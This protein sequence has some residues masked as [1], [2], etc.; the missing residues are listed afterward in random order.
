M[1]HQSDR[2][3]SSMSPP[4]TRAWVTVV[5]VGVVAAA[6]I[7][8]L[9]VALPLL[10][11]ELGMSLVTAG[12]LVGVIQLASMVGG[13][14]VAW[15]GEMAGLRRLI[16]IGLLLLAVG[17]CLGATTSSANLMMVFR[18][19]EG[20]GFLLCT[21]LAPALIRRICR[22]EQLNL[23][24]SSWGAF[25]GTATVVGFAGG[26][27]LLEFVSWRVLWV[28]MAAFT[29][30][31][32]V[33][34]ARFTEVDPPASADNKLKESVTRI[35]QT[36][37]TERPWVAGLAFASYTLQ[38]MAV[39]GFLPTVFVAADIER[40]PAALLSAVV[41]GV[42]IIG[43]LMVA[44]LLGRGFRPRYIL[45][46]T[47]LV[48]ALSSIAFFAVDWPASPVGLIGQLGCA[49]LFSMIGGTIPA[50]LSRMAVDLAP[51]EG[52]VAAVIGLMQQIFNVGNFFGPAVLAW[53][54]TM[55]GSW[56]ASWWV[57]C[58]CSLIGIAAAMYLTR[59]PQKASPAGER[60]ER[61]QT[62]LGNPTS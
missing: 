13:L 57:T 38:W 44:T 26:G 19:L 18:S 33:L 52:S 51:Q 46:I 5:T 7:W 27:V 37:R 14:L 22:P 49:I 62:A 48:M 21:V 36:V 39:M 17:S 10:E 9:P 35:A 31:L 32:L 41:G 2:R 55:T 40:L 53:V 4:T 59:N 43:A 45:S 25:Q 11:A 29:L 24:L 50:L 3:I 6:H 28:V 8:K 1:T 20:I 12:M 47:F 60:H 42:N 30:V 54:V 16:M 61:V 56:E 15:G 34:V 23:A 58:S